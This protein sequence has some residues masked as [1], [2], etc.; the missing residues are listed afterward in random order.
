I[1]MRTLA[2]HREPTAMPEATVA[3]EVHQSLDVHRRFAAQVALDRVVAVDGLADADD[4]VVG[5]RVDATRLIYPHFPQDLLGLR[6]AD[7]VDVLQPYHHALGGGNVHTGYTSQNPF[8]F[9]HL[10][11]ADARPCDVPL[12]PE[13][14]AII[15][16]RAFESTDLPIV[17]PPPKQRRF[18]DKPRPSRPCH[19]PSSG[20]RALGNRAAGARSGRDRRPSGSSWSLQ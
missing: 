1:G 4:L 19:R 16:I 8:S 6:L 3:G 12:A 11:R 5:Q 10:R 15:G 18:D 7:P 17:K 14:R 13:K 9:K 2:A 20:P